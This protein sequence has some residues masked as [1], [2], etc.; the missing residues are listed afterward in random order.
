MQKI[1]NRRGAF[2]DYKLKNLKI[3]KYSIKIPQN[4]ST[5]YCKNKKTL[6]IVGPVKRKSLKLKLKILNNETQ[7][8]ISVSPFSFFK[9]SKAEKKQIKIMQRSAI[10]QIKQLLIESS[11]KIYQKLTIIGVGYRADVTETLLKEKIL[12]LKLGFSHLVHVKIPENLELTCLT[13]TKICIYGNSYDELSKISATI[14]TQKVPEVYKGK[15]VRYENEK[16]LL[17]EGKK[18]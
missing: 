12:T 8:K 5:I 17:K 6:T 2:T 4:T 15:G 16:I 14:R 1:K 10:A 13:K 7:K 3:N 11:I 18:I 9:I